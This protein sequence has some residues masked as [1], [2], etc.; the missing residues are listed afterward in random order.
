M[1]LAKNLKFAIDDLLKKEFKIFKL[2]LDNILF[3]R[4]KNVVNIKLLFTKDYDYIEYFNQ[5]LK[6]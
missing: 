6:D 1:F 3:F 4:N 5:I 2:N